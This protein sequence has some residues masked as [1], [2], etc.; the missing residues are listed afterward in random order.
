MGFK[1]M[2]GRK[3]PQNEKGSG[4][5]EIITANKNKLKALSYINFAYLND[6][7][8]PFPWLYLTLS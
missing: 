5:R 7:Y 1:K 6:L 3:Y 2:K 4:V 8:H